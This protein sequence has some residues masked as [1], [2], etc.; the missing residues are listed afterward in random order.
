MPGCSL[1]LE[2]ED[3]ARVRRPGETLRGHVLVRAASA[4]EGRLELQH[5]WRARGSGMEEHGR[6]STHLLA[7]GRLETGESDRFEFELDCLPGPF[8]HAGELFQLDW[9]LRA[10]L[11][12]EG[13]V[14]AEVEE[15]YPLEPSRDESEVP[16]VPAPLVVS[17]PP[18]QLDSTSRTFAWL[19]G[20]GPSLLGLALIGIGLSKAWDTAGPADPEET[21][22]RTVLQLPAG[23]LCCALGA[24]VCFGLWRRRQRG[25]VLGR[26]GIELSN[27][28][29]RP[30]ELLRVGLTL[31]PRESVHLEEAR[32]ILRLS[33]DV[34]EDARRE[35]WST[36]LLAETE[37]ALLPAGPC[38]A[39]LEQTGQVELALPEDAPFTHTG[40]RH[41]LRCELDVLVRA[42]DATLRRTS[43]E[44]FIVP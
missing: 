28:A 9:F 35:R 2:L 16:R 4:L 39:E 6:P 17:E 30:G 1:E 24:A 7:E 27:T 31:C 15:S 38:E 37:G 25:R 33:E 21:L 26:L 29:L 19:L 8:S 36:R 12:A 42:R 44:L 3:P 18:P 32:A 5:S 23:G 40:D 10:R 34:L 13:G 43:Y 41:R 22:I 20:V 11:L 14:T